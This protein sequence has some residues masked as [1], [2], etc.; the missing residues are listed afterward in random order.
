VTTDETGEALY[1]AYLADRIKKG[2][3][4]QIFLAPLH[5]RIVAQKTLRALEQFVEH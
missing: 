3:I 4:R 2:G 5:E 1:Q